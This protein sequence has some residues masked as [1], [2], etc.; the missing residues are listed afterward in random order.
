[1][2]SRARQQHLLKT[3]ISDGVGGWDL[4]GLRAQEVACPLPLRL[5]G[6]SLIPAQASKVIHVTQTLLR[7][8]FTTLTHIRRSMAKDFGPMDP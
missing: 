3:T 2:K 4:K 7:F 1:M 5:Y 8:L 6:K